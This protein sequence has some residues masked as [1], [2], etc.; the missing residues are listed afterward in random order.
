MKERNKH[1][2]VR[3]NTRSHHRVGGVGQVLV[4]PKR[5]AETGAPESWQKV[6]TSAFSSFSSD[7][8]ELEGIGASAR[9]RTREYHFILERFAFMLQRYMW[10][11]CCRCRCDYSWSR[12]RCNGIA[13]AS[14]AA[15]PPLVACD[16]FSITAGRCCKRIA[17]LTSAWAVK[18]L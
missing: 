9:K 14:D 1:S 5:H 6:S 7:P 11:R 10:L 4:S 18:R 3:L 17:S 16:G 15:L 13:V 2:N 8:T 12:E